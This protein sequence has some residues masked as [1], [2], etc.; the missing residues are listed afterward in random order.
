MAAA[1]FS[2]EKG[3]FQCKKHNDYIQL[4]KG[5]KIDRPGVR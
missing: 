2:T 1:F 5:E 3:G 4:G